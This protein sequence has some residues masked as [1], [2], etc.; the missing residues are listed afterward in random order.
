[1]GA[2]EVGTLDAMRRFRDTLWT[3]VANRFGGRIVGAAGDSFLIEFNSAVAAL[4][5]AVEIQKGMAEHNATVPDATRMQL[6]LGINIGEI[7]VDDEGIFGDGV[8]I[9]ARMQALADA[10]GICISGA[11][12]EQV[13]GKLDLGFADL[14]PQDVKNIARP[15]P[16]Y[17]VLLN[18]S[19]A[20]KTVS[21]A[22]ARSR[23][24]MAPYAAALAAIAVL[25]F[26][27]VYWTLS[28]ASDDQAPIRLLVLPYGSANTQSEPFATAASE[29]LW[30]TLSRLKGLSLVGR[31]HAL[32]LK[33]IQPSFAQMSQNGQVTH[34]LDGTVEKDGADVIVKSRLRALSGGQATETRTWQTTVAAD[35]LFSAL[36]RHKTGLTSEL[37]VPLNADEREIVEQAPTESAEAYALYA[38]GMQAWMTGEISGVASALGLLEAAK[39]AEPAFLDA[40]GAYAYLNFFVWHMGWN[41]VRNN[42]QALEIAEKTIAD[43]LADDPLNTDALIVEVDIARHLDRDKALT[44]ARGAIFRKRDDPHLRLALGWALLSNGLVDDA[45][46]EFETYQNL[47]PRLRPPEVLDLANAYLRLDDPARA[48]EVISTLDPE[49][50]N[51]FLVLAAKAEIFARLGRLEEGRAQARKFLQF[52]PFY[53]VMWDEPKFRTFK[54]P[55]VFQAYSKAMQAVGI[56]LWPLAFDQ[57]RDDARLGN[58]ALRH[59]F[60]RSFRTVET[61]DPV[62][63]PYTSQYTVDG[64]VTLAYGF[65]QGMTFTG[66]WDI[67][68]D[69]VCQTFPSI[70]MGMRVCERV[71]VDRERS[72]AEDPRYVQLNGFGVHRF[73]VDYLDD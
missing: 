51:G 65:M 16:T 15:V 41:P 13:R 40:R 11:V 60:G 64:S 7:I 50:A 29:N 18:P 33:G 31:G 44:L 67:D 35:Q 39:A 61:T 52:L 71:Y 55:A 3:P 62:G 66:M 1:M 53:S 14:G 2:D 8:N 57:G 42:K 25:A 6:R 12:Y 26:A 4:E 72:T 21:A 23:R 59:L 10:G 73:G 54:D 49:A 36:A 9:A 28:R 69:H 47:S 68:G 56:P 19:D 34:V 58:A 27:A 43:L 45:R 32:E 37:K 24:T 22:P 38:E 5:A 30:L 20:G 48:L 17:R 63:G 46:A 70:S